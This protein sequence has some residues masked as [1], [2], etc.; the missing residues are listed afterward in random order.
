VDLLVV[1]DDP[2]E[3]LM[4]RRGLEQDGHR[5]TA[6]NNGKEALRHLK[7]I[8][9]FN[10]IVVDWMMPDMDG[11]AFLATLQR[12]VDKPPPVLVVTSLGTALARDRALAAGAADFISKPVRPEDLIARI[13]SCIAVGASDSSTPTPAAPEKDLPVLCLLAGSGDQA[14]VVQV[15]GA[16]RT[17][18]PKCA[19]FIIQEGPDWVR[20][21]LSDQLGVAGFTLRDSLD[22]AALDGGVFVLNPDRQPKLASKV[23]GGDDSD[24]RSAGGDPLLC[25]LASTY[26]RRLTV[27]VLGRTALAGTV[28]A[29]YAKV[30]GSAVLI[31]ATR[32]GSSRSCDQIRDLNQ[33]TEDLPFEALVTAL[34]THL[35]RLT[36]T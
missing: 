15:L 32:P 5:V 17:R 8:A 14:A 22:G 11:I 16:V 30:A 35:A 33:A 6:A 10:A 27:V 9:R 36:G 21:K 26:G 29:G 24:D 31:E 28:G 4:L 7:Q 13:R 19:T 3:A 2:F 25:S 20:A 1:E 23:F 12:L 18:L 34:K